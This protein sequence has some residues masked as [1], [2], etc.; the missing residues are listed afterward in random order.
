[1][2]KKHAIGSRRD[3]SFV[4]TSLPHLGSNIEKENSMTFCLFLWPGKSRPR[5]DLSTGPSRAL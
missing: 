5:L 4:S 1:M 2:L 3:I